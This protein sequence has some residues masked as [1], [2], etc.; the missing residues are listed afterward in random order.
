V[1]FRFTTNGFPSPQ[2]SVAFGAL[3]AGLLL[4]AT[5]GAL[6]GTPTQAGSYSFTIAADNG[7]GSPAT[8]QISHEVLPLS[9]YVY[10][11]FIST[12]P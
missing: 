8:Q 10:L 5:S 12:A 6:S 4:N 1:N 7:V 3:P 11:P 9:N 2:F